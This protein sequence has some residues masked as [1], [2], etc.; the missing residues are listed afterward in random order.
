MYFL[1]YEYVSHG[2][3]S[4]RVGLIYHMH[5]LYIIGYWLQDDLYVLGTTGLKYVNKKWEYE[6]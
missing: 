6:T 1:A 3:M 5:M 4:L 2:W